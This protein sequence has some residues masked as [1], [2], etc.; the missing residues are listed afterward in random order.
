MKTFKYTLILLLACLSMQSCQEI[1]EPQNTVP[2]VVTDA[3]EKYSGYMAY[4]SGSVTSRANCY[5]LLSTQTDLSDARKL[6]VYPRYDEEQGKW[7]C[8]SEAGNLQAGTTYYVA[9]CATDGRSEV[10]GNVVEFTTSSYLS[11]E[12][13]TYNGRELDWDIFSLYITDS[14]NR[15]EPDAGNLRVEKSY[16]DNNLYW[17][18]PYDFLLSKSSYKVYACAYNKENPSGSLDRIPVSVRGHEDCVYGSDQV[19]PENPKA[20]IELKSALATL[21]FMISTDN[22][23][24]ISVYFN[25]R[26]NGNLPTGTER[27]SISGTLDLTTGKITPIPIAGHDGI[28]FKTDIK[29][30]ASIEATV[31]IIPTSFKDGELELVAYIGNQPII[32]PLSA[33]TWEGGKDYEIPVT[34]SVPKDNSKAKVGDYYYSDG[35]WSTTY[36]ADKECIGIVF[37]LSEKA[38]GDIDVS[39][40]ESEHGRIVALEDAGYSRWGAEDHIADALI[41]GRLYQNAPDFGY[42]PVDGKDKY[43][44][45]ENMPS[46]QI[47]YSYENWPTPSADINPKWALF[48]YK[49]SDWTHYFGYGDTA[50]AMCYSYKKGDFQ[51]YLPSVGEM[52]RFAMAYAYGIISNSKQNVFENPTTDRAYWTSCANYRSITGSASSAWGYSTLTHLLK[53]HDIADRMCIRPIAS[54]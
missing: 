53:P 18:L 13:V 14:E 39:L 40:K 12:S 49:G 48:D 52:A 34:V 4:L 6:D 28:T 2:T 51:W 37:A 20:N 22:A 38:Y 23:E 1:E 9:L 30:E 8:Q 54:F 32:I 19:T 5:F 47:P 50:A 17:K 25:L 43:I 27:L 10:K 16:V 42:L 35:T 36:N 11:I 26:N 7:F 31:K 44:Y 15:I 29:P 45:V 21:H 46:P 24:S 33:S 41:F 3:V